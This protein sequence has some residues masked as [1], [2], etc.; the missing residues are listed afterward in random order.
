MASTASGSI[1]RQLGLRADER[2]ALYCEIADAA[3][4]TDL[5]FWTVLM[6]AGAIATLGLVLNSTAVVIGAMLVA[7]LLGPLLGLSLSVAVGDGRLFVQTALSILAGATAIVALAA[8]VTWL[9]PIDTVTDEIAARTRPNTLDLLIA[10][11]SG[12]AGAVVM[13]SRE[14]RLSGSI[15]GVAVAVALVPPLGV[16][17]FGIG[18]GFQ[19]PIISGSLLLFGANLAGIVLSGLA[20]FLAVGM[21]RPEVVARAK[22]WHTE[23]RAT[24]LARSCEGL[25]L[26]RTL[27]VASSPLK[28]MAL[29]ALFVAAVSFPLARSFAHIVREV[30]VAS[31]ADAAKTELEADGGTLVLERAIEQSGDDAAVTFRIATQTRVDDEERERLARTMTR[32]AGEPVTLTLTQIVVPSGKLAE[33]ARELPSAPPLRA[34]TPPATTADLLRPLQERLADGLSGVLLPAGAR[35]VGASLQISPNG[36]P[37]LSVVYGGAEP[38]SPDAAALVARQAARA[39]DIDPASAVPVFL[40]LGERALPSPDG[41]A[42]LRGDL[43]RWPRLAATVLGT[44]ERADDAAARLATSS[45]GQ[46]TRAEGAAGLRLCVRGADDPPGCPAPPAP[47]GAT[48]P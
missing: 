44:G 31:A 28:R 20:V 26:P 46:V 5:P 22:A 13:A 12:L 27:D 48:L 7:P 4:D 16:A 9:L 15:P 47:D 17:G 14:T 29:T 3:T 11:F 41:A 43:R 37:A 19:W 36:A 24:G 45:P 21:H 40:P 23:D 18:T 25:T 2:P 1:G 34:V 35:L 30:K 38:L 42:R 10:I 33:A 39:L 6:L 32:A 8:L